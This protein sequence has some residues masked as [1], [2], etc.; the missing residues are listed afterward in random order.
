MEEASPPPSKFPLPFPTIP[1]EK[2]V[3]QEAL[4]PEPVGG[5]FPRKHQDG[6]VNSIEPMKVIKKRRSRVAKVAENGLGFRSKGV[7]GALPAG[8]QVRP[9]IV[10]ASAGAVSSGLDG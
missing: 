2:N 5:P 6:N 10:G 3:T 9:R 7:N 8:V 4:G 1:A